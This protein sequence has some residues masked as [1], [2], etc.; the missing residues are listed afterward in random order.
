MSDF[1][2]AKRFTASALGVLLARVIALVAVFGLNAILARSLSPEDFG[3][4]VLFFSLTGLASLVACVGLNRSIVKKIAASRNICRQSAHRL[5]RF[6][7]LIAIVGGSIVGFIAGVGSY[8]LLPE[9][10]TVST[11]LRAFLFGGMILVRTVH[12]VLAEAARGFHERIWSNLFGGLGGGPV[13]H[14]LFVGLLLLPHGYGHDSLAVALGLYLVAFTGTLP[15]LWMR[16]FALGNEDFEQD[17]AEQSDLARKPVADGLLALGVPLMLTQACGLAMSQGDIWIAGA[18]AAPAAVAM[19]AAAQRMLALL[20]IPLQI[21][22]TA[23]VNFVPELAAKDKPKLQ[24]MVGLAATVGGLPGIALA[25]IFMVFAEQILAI[26]FGSHYADSAHIL[27]I[28]TAAQFVCLATGPCEIVLMMAGQ[29]N[30]TL[31]V[32]VCAATALVIVGP[33]ATFGY[34]MYG[35]AAA[36]ATVTAT[37]N[38]VNWYL[39]R[40][41]LGISTHVGAVFWKLPTLQPFVFQTKS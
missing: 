40:R 36:I 13:P 31:R 38:L 25:L 22:G 27:R 41:L 4:F 20:T 39:A 17:L 32:N 7:L 18:M 26:V 12:L 8:I 19:Y 24:N 2:I 14:L 33:L 15:L 6:G 34:G 21:A 16:V 1:A 28:L 23:I 37:Q 3:A 5:L 9:S 30:A 35:L 10:A 29:Q 11:S